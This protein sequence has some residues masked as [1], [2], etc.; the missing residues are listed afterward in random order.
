M[1]HN[2]VKDVISVAKRS[3][4]MIIS[5]KSMDIQFRSVH[6]DLEVRTTMAYVV[7]SNVNVLR[8]PGLNSQDM[9]VIF[10]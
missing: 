1:R 3:A 8:S 6:L 4:C 2:E 10:S 9:A 5:L 7:C